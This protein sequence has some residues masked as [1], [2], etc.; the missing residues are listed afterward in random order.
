M[1]LSET[2]YVVALHLALSDDEVQ[3]MAGELNVVGYLSNSA[4]LMPTRRTHA[5]MWRDITVE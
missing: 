2:M 3:Q 1:S 4:K 5:N